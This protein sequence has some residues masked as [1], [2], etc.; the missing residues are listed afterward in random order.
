[1]D[2]RAKRQQ[3]NTIQTMQSSY[4]IVPSERE[5]TKLNQRDQARRPSSVRLASP[6]PEFTLIRCHHG[7][8]G[9]RW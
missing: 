3:L 8:E 4:E 9:G 5:W 1:M 6:R 2:R 7:E